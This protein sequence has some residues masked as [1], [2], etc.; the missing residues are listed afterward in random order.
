MIN[1]LELNED[2]FKNY[3]N[4]YVILV[5]LELYCTHTKLYIGTN[6][7]KIH[8]FIWTIKQNKNS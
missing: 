1:K 2:D 7:G 3:Q 6:C 5:S 4:K 8:V